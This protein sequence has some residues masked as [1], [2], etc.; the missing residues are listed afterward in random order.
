MLKKLQTVLALSFMASYASAGTTVLGTAS[1][2]GNMRVDGYTVRGDATVFNGSVVET[3]DAS[4][5]LRMGHGVDI[6]M[7][8]SSRGTIYRDHF[9]LQRGASELT[10][11]ASFQLEANGL[12]VSSAAPNTVGVV[13]V[14]P[15]NAVEI[16]T[17]SGS[18][19]VR[20]GEGLLLSNVLPG[21]PLTFAMQTEAS[22]SPQFIS[23]VG[24]LD[25]QNGQYY[26]TTDDNVKYVLTGTDQLQKF[27]G[28]KVVVTGMFNSAAPPAGTAGTIAVKTIYVNPGGPGGG[29]TK[30]GKWLIVATAL[31]G[32]GT[33]G[34]VIYDAEQNPPVSR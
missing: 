9:V 1:V 2:R 19:A 21:R 29:I 17:L 15:Q 32:A 11:P 6:T 4:A 28:D 23:T 30:K 20:D 12:R 3:A 34:W 25:Y 5:S 22:T 13:T 14:T 31:G 27:V 24:L 26:F 8:K 33:V 10:A 18:F 16:A 7:S